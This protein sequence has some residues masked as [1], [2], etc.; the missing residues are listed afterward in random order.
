MQSVYDYSTQ[1]VE[2]K[3]TNQSIIELENND[4][5]RTLDKYGKV[6]VHVSE[7]QAYGDQVAM[8]NVLIT[9]IYSL[10]AQNFYEA[11]SLPLGSNL[12]IPIKFQNEKAHLFANEI[13]GI[14]VGVELSHPRVVTADLGNY[15]SSLILQSQGTGECNVK[16]YLIKNPS[17]FDVFKVRV[18]TL[19][20]PS[21]PVHLHVGSDVSFK[22]V[23][24]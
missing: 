11:L 3:Q 14:Q 15:N 7:D 18:A 6:T 9:D 12:D 22:I 21:S 19:V 2:Y 24:D 4:S 20:Q 16:I 8:L 1:R 10:S 23:N 5:I 13:E 17:I